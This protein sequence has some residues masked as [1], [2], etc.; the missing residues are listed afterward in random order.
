[1]GYFIYK[2]IVR[3]EYKKIVTLGILLLIIS[4]FPI[5][6]SNYIYVKYTEKNN[7]ANVVIIQ[8]SIDPYNEK[9]SG[10]TNEQ[11][12]DIMFNLAE[13]NIDST[14]DYVVCPET[15]IDDRL[16]ESDISTN[17]SIVRIKNFVLGHPR[18]K[19]VTGLS[20]YKMYKT[21][22][23]ITYTARPYPFEKGYYYDYYNSAIQ[24]DTTKNY[25]IYHKSKLVAGVEMMPYPKQMKLLEKFSIDLGGISGH[26]GTQAN[27]DV[28]FSSDKKFGVGPVICYESDFGE[29]MSGYIKN[30]ANLI[31]VM[32]NDGWWG[33]TPGHRQHLTFSQIR[34]IELR[35]SIA[36]SANTGISAIINQ[37]GEILESLGWWKRD[38]IKGSINANSETT[39]YARNGDYIG[40][41][42]T[43]LAGF[44]LLFTIIRRVVTR[45]K[46]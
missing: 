10:L 23:A 43:Y 31:F 32:T 18:V 45:K 40:K 42:A 20:T 8:P 28:F 12:M 25:P 46:K 14:T 21:G 34:A 22:E 2:F 37:R 26:A 11:Q 30:G 7:P 4:V 5:V 3:R 17:N 1:L 6:I 35:R 13:T 36:R 16:W 29:Y 38:V 9:F 44:I 39:F 19:W 24:I 41:F 27:R 15:A 33:N